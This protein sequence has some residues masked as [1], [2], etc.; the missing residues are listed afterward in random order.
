[1]ILEKYGVRAELH[2]DFTQLQFENYQNRLLEQ[3]KDV[4]A[5]AVVERALVEAAVE[6]GILTGVEKPITE[7]P[8]R[9]V[10]WLTIKARDFINEQTEVQQD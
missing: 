5:I 2:E 6:A 1:M 9:V 10:R 4:K 8:P 3:T 7:L